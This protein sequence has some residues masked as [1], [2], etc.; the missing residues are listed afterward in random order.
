MTERERKEHERRARRS[1][2][3]QL[4]PPLDVALA[5]AAHLAGNPWPEPPVDPWGPE[6]SALIR[7]RGSR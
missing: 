2:A 4:S 7:S 5:T 1:L 3:W 6:V